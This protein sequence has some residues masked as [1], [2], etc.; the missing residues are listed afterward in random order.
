MGQVQ[1]SWIL[2]GAELVLRIKEKASS[3]E[4]AFCVSRN[5][6]PLRR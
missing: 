2:E 1:E 4:D 3:V 6:G 5:M